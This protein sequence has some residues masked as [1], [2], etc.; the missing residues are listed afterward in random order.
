MKNPNEI[1]IP[2]K[3]KKGKSYTLHFGYSKHKTGPTIYFIKSVPFLDE[4][5]ENILNKARKEAFKIVK[6]IV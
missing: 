5:D 2:L 1:K 6:R 4:E 3:G